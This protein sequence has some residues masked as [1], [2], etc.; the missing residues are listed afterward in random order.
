LK[1]IRINRVEDC[2]DSSRVYRYTFDQAWTQ[3]RIHALRSLGPLDYYADFPRPF[4]RLRGSGGFQFK[5]VEGETSCQAIFAKL[6]RQAIKTNFEG[7]FR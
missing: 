4:F 3:E 2:F 7:R 5:G 1:I 6:D